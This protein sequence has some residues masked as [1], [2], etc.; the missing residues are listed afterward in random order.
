MTNIAAAEA[1]KF[2]GVPENMNWY[3]R[4]GYH[5]Q[6]HEDFCMLLNLIQNRLHGDQLSDRFGNIPF[7]KP[8]PIFDW[9]A[10]QSNS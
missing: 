6:N 1:F 2:L 10:P 7:E 4:D 9:V 3:Y 8:E 5:N